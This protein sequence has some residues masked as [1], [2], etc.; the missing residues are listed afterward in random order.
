MSRGTASIGRCRA[1]RSAHKGV[2]LE[3]GARI[4]TIQNSC[5]TIQKGKR[6][7]FRNT[8]QLPKDNQTG[9]EML[10]H[11]TLASENVMNGD[12]KRQH[13]NRRRFL[14]AS[15]ALPLG[16]LLKHTTSAAQ[17]NVLPPISVTAPRPPDFNFGDF[18]INSNEI[19]GANIGAGIPPPSVCFNQYCASNYMLLFCEH[20]QHGSRDRNVLQVFA[21]NRTQRHK[22]LAQS[23]C[24]GRRIHA[25]A[26]HRRLQVFARRQPIWV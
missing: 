9:C 3:A 6:C 1:S 8:N 18:K 22:L 7:V 25:M 23:A 13:Q 26:G 21:G 20:G 10:K 19:P 16:T 17:S 4:R 15:T 24:A 14:I 12:N 5:R 2:P 11:D